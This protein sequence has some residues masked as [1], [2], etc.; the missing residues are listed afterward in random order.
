[1]GSSVYF[2]VNVKGEEK[3]INVGH[4]SR[5]K[6]ACRINII[7]RD[8]T[9]VAFCAPRN[10]S[11]ENPRENPFGEIGE[12]L[13]EWESRVHP[14]DL[15]Q[16]LEAI[17]RHLDGKTSIYSN[18]HRVR[19]KD[20]SY[21]WIL[22]RGRVTSRTRSDRPRR[23]VGTHTDIQARKEAES[24]LN[25]QRDFAVALSATDDLTGRLRSFWIQVRQS[26][27]LTAGEYIL[28]TRNNVPWSWLAT[29]A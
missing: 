14:D 20:S 23:V 19:C 10:G 26:R 17:R 9:K 3:Y 18:E 15:G 28:S 12:T 6:I 16:C 22:D 11:D 24:L 29:A 8:S 2:T 4:L 27:G 5:G 1:V 7:W 25:M 21:K 13:D